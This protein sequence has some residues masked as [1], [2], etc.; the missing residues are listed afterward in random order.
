M[1]DIAGL[2]EFSSELVKIKLIRTIYIFIK[3]SLS[4]Y[5][6]N[7]KFLRLPNLFGFI[8][9]Q[10]TTIFLKKSITIDVILLKFSRSSRFTNKE[11]SALLASA[12]ILWG[13]SAP[14]PLYII[15][16]ICV[17]GTH[18]SSSSRRCILWTLF[19][20]SMNAACSG[21]D[22]RS[23]AMEI[24]FPAEMLPTLLLNETQN[25][26]LAIASVT[27]DSSLQCWRCHTVWPLTSLDTC[28][29]L[30]T[31]P[32]CTSVTR[33]NVASGCWFFCSGERNSHYTECNSVNPF[34]CMWIHS[35]RKLINSLSIIIINKLMVC[36]YIITMH[37]VA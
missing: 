14:W 10:L 31:A 19:P 4:Y 32:Y 9:Y 27:R 8:L 24:H 7:K 2:Q 23:T 33:R 6:M 3:Q 17:W 1:D 36:V 5:L 25:S 22:C 29:P 18:F 34:R 11:L 30:F 26:E 37:A 15:C 21:L 20:A 12:I 16:F 35:Y 13:Q 28:S